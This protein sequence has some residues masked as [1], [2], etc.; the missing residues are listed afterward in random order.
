MEILTVVGILQFLTKQGVWS[1]RC[2]RGLLL[3]DAYLDAVRHGLPLFSICASSVKL[4][5]QR[6]I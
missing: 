5:K 4:V 3:G 6:G 2:L 1:A